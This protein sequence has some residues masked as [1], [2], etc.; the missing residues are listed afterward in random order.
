[1]T[2]FIEKNL[3]AF[4]STLKI[5]KTR[6]NLDQKP[7]P[8]INNYE[9]TNKKGG[10]KKEGNLPKALPSFSISH[11]LLSLFPTT[12]LHKKNYLPNLKFQEFE[13]ARILKIQKTRP[14]LNHNHHIL[15]KNHEKRSKKG[16][17]K[18]EDNLRKPLPSFSFF[19][20]LLSIYRV[21]HLTFGI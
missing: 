18:K 4:I 3:Y 9:K 20:P 6:P 1:M 5:Q 21:G 2:R 16:G 8:K 10:K 15:I 19:R 13:S 11:P 14:N 17:K 12:Y 7:L